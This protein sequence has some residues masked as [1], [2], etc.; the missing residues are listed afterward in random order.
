MAQTLQLASNRYLRSRKTSLLTNFD[1]ETKI[2][3]KSHCEDSKEN[4]LAIF[5]HFSMQK[6]PI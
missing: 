5:R 4:F 2:S 1:R 3:V 6:D